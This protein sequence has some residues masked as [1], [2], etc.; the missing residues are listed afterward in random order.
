VES[1]AL[2]MR[3]ARLLRRVE[4]PGR[5]T[6]GETH[7][8]VKDP[9]ETKASLVL[10][11]PDLYDI[12]MSYHGFKILYERVNGQPGR[13][14]E[15]AF[16][17]WPDMEEAMRREGLP[18]YALESKRPVA[19]FDLIG[20][21]LQHEVNYTNV[22]NMLD[23][24]GLPVEASERSAPLPLV[25]GGGEGAYNPEPLSRF[26][27][28]FVVGDGE[29]SLDRL[30]HLV[31]QAKAE[32]TIDKEDLLR[33]ASEVPG[34]Y[35]PSYYEVEYRKDGCIDRYTVKGAKEASAPKPIR[36]ALYDLR[37]DLGSVM[38]IIPTCA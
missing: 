3:L 10:A 37:R 19:E 5:Y 28:L 13:A 18:L 23:L 14:A 12:G 16:A 27:D 35:V 32:G 9:L 1:N 15:R 26:F 36:K 24:A 38:P 11:F 8:I 20:F 17:P 7:Q 29:E 2:T 6:G 25:I 30:M 33:R 21:T 31:E 22:L 34:V 4:K